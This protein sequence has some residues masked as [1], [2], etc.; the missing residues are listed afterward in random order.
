M[1][2]SG[3]VF[4][5]Y[6]MEDAIEAIDF[7]ALGLLLGMMMIVS[8]LEPT[9]FFEYLAVMAARASKGQPV[10]LF[11][12]LGT[13]TTVLSMFLDNV[14]TVVLIAPVTLLISEILGVSAIP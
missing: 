11:I 10:R 7:E 6:H 8:M 2:V 5:F 4:A 9:G 12:L 3:V 1:M 13:V 14:T